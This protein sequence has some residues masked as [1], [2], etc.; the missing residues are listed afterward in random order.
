MTR[1]CAININSEESSGGF[2]PVVR[3]SLER[4]KRADTHLDIECIEP[5]LDRAL[6]VNSTYFSLLNQASIADKAH[7]LSVAGKHDALLVLCFLD[8]GVQEAQELSSV[9]VVGVG[10]A[11]MLLAC[12]LGRKFAIV[13][14]D[15]PKMALQIERN[16]RLYGMESHAIRDPIVPVGIP[17]RE[18]LTRGMA[19]PGFV[20]AEIRSKAELCVARGADVVIIGCVG[21]SSIATMTGLARLEDG[22]VPV[23]DCVQA[24]LKM[25]ELRADCCKLGWPAVG[26]S[27]LYAQPRAKDLERVRSIFVAR[28]GGAR[29]VP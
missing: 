25:A 29:H 11:S 27:G 15:E 14:L 4:A 6:D 3:N 22:D 17:S 9:P 1:I 2:L 8:P 18:W 19:E 24:G 21:L 26:R 5:G 20:A 7:A 10:H 23:L 13:T 28:K 12:Q 16:L